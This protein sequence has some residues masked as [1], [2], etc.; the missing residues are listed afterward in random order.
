M[1]TR[2]FRWTHKHRNQFG[3][4]IDADHR[5]VRRASS[6]EGYDHCRSCSMPIVREPIPVSVRP[7]A[8]G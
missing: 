5:P 7:I 4:S 2:R 8:D 1:N 3:R 6:I